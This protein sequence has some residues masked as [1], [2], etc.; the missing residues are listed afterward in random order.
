[1]AEINITPL[2]PNTEKNYQV[3]Q[4]VGEI[5]R[6]TITH[7]KEIME[8]YLATFAQGN[9]ILDL[10]NLMFT[11]SEGIGYVTDV[12]NRLQAQGKKVVIVNASERIM[13]IFNLVGLNSLIPCMTSEE[14]AAA[15]F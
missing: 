4:V 3:L 12:F 9:L 2:D 14:E 15:T 8:Q 7:L 13:D 10:Q 11:N 6:D 5:D 1:M